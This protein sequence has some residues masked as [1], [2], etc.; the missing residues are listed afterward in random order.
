[1]VDYSKAIETL[2]GTKEDLIIIG[3]TGRTGA[4]CSTAAKIMGSEEK[5]L[6]FEYPD[7]S[8]WKKDD[9][10]KFEII[11][12]YITQESRWIP[13]DVIEVSCVILSFV[14]SYNENGKSAIE[15]LIDYLEKEQGKKGNV[16]LKIVNFDNL[17]GQIKSLKEV[18]NEIKNYPLDDM[19]KKKIGDY[20]DFYMRKMPEYKNI[21]KNI[22]QNYS[23]YEIEKSKLQDHKQTKYH[24]YTYL[25]QKWGNNIRATG[26]PYKSELNQKEYY[27]LA[28]RIQKL[29]ELIKD[30]RDGKTRICIDAIRN[31][32]ESNYLKSRYRGYYLLSISVDDVSR[33]NRL[34]SL[35]ANEQDSID[36]VEYA[37]KYESEDFFY[38]QNI[39]QCFEMADIHIY[40]ED[41]G[42]QKKFFLTWQLVKYITLMMHPGLIT[43]THIERCMQLA[44]NA[45]YNSGCLS[46]QVGA[47][48]TGADFAI[49]SVGWNDVPKGHVPCNLRDVRAYCRGNE[50]VCYSEFECFDEQFD[51]AMKN[52]NSVLKKNNKNQRFPYCFKDVYNAY[53]NSKNQVFTRALHAEENAFLQISKY[54][55]QGIEEGYLFCTASPCELCSKKAYQLGIR[56]IYY[57]DPYPGIAEKHIIRVGE[58]KNRPTMNLFYGAIGDAYISLYRPLL[59][60]KDELELLT[61]IDIKKAIKDGDKYGNTEPQTSDLRYEKIDFKI[62]F[63]SREEIESTR[64]VKF[65]IE[66]GTLEGIDRRLTWTGSSYFGTELVQGDYELKDYGDK[67]SPYRYYID[68]K[69]NTCKEIEYTV[70]SKVRDEGHLMHEYF[71]HY[72][73]YPTDKLTLEIEVPKD[74][75]RNVHFQL[76]ADKEM[77]IPYI[78][79][80]KEIEIETYRD[81]AIEKYF[82]NIQFPILFYTYSLEW[83]FN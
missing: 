1:M 61:G 42:N 8:E 33:R 26:D 9:K 62:K 69:G 3:L 73:K 56:N 22:L 34:K 40:N 64:A 75:I 55:G 70:R 20:Y 52:I 2:Y 43:P 57:I 83:E 59:P 5:K 15:N 63:I 50:A 21:L 76:Y 46:R 37:K 77:K 39:A 74:L 65:V 14:F 45:K 54:G 10:F 49:K 58:E 60:Y 53:N 28:M 82:V 81:D 44:F 29:V 30:Y 24:L 11:K 35:N 23:C 6:D 67:T 16:I 27:S 18:C 36:N 32:N 68:F 41:V 13:F 25:M 80:N 31:V 66:N 4:G 12:E 78:D 19:D 72:V 48:V 47:V 38:H 7:K 71:S 79:R 17:K 51:I